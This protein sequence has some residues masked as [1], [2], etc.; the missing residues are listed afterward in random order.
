MT[1]KT[2]LL[3]RFRFVLI[4]VALILG[5]A[6]LANAQEDDEWNIQFEHQIVALPEPLAKP[7]IKDLLDNK[8]SE[9]AHARLQA[10]IIEGKAAL[11]AWSTIKAKSRQ[12]AIIS[13]LNEEYY[14]SEY[15]ELHMASHVTEGA[16][17]AAAYDVKFELTTFD[18]APAKIESAK[19]GLELNASATVY[20]NGELIDVALTSKHVRKKEFSLEAPA[21]VEKLAFTRMENNGHFYIRNKQWILTGIH[22]SSEPQIQIQL[23]RVEAIKIH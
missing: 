23:L 18:R 15:E 21:A 14:V 22:K 9:A 16:D 6:N 11:T 7:L 2:C 8:K 3:I 20:K 10:M 13:V 4:S 19:L 17:L 1:S 12:S 5:L